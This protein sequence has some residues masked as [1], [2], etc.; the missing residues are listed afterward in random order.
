MVRYVPNVVT[1]IEAC[2]YLGSEGSC[3][4]FWKGKVIQRGVG[5]GDFPGEI[6]SV[7]ERFGVLQEGFG[8]MWLLLDGT[9]RCMC[10]EYMY[11]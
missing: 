6:I 11:E 3:K 7:L 10:F 5:S 8:I 1:P 2:D 4:G 9:L